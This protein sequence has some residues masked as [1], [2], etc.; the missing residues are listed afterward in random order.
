MV[1]STILGPDGA[2]IVLPDL[3]QPQTAQLTSLQHEWQGHPTRG[4]TPT[5]L[6]GIMDAAEQGDW[7]AQCELYDDMEEKD[8]H[9]AS[10]MGKR[11]RAI[12]LLDWDIVPPPSPYAS[13]KRAAKQVK[14][15]LADIPE[16]EDALFDVTDAIGKGFCCLEIEWH[17]V[18]G[19]WL[20]KTLTH[21]P[22]QWF[23]VQRGYREAIR[24]RHGGGEGE[25]LQPFGWITHTHKAKSGWLA[26]SAL[27]RVLAWPYL[28]KNYSVADLAEFLEIYGIPLRVGK[29]PPGAGEK[30]KLTLLRALA[31]LGHKAA[32]IIPE[33]MLIE[34]QEA[35]KGDP[36]S[37]QLMIDW[38]EKSQSKAILGGTL[39][40]QADGKTSTNALGN[41]HNEVR[42]DLRD[43]DVKQIAA[44]LSR[45]L[46]YAI[47]AL[48]GLAPN[49][50]RRAPRWHYPTEEPEDLATYSSALPPLV[51]MGM[52]IPRKWAQEKLG[53]PEPEADDDDLLIA[54]KPAA[55]APF[56]N[57][58]PAD[59]AAATAHTASATTL[60]V[61]QTS[62]YAPPDLR[63]LD[64]LLDDIEQGNTQQAE[65][66]Q[67][68]QPLLDAA[69]QGEQ[70]LADK[71]GSLFPA[72]DDGALEDALD[73]LLFAAQAWG[74]IN[75]GRR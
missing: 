59:Q 60:P 56:A 21:R 3:A 4:L 72:L 11:R 31:G 15:W 65:A 58:P 28:F 20:P 46:V 30:E 24:L 40:S 9:I 1:T 73:R 45:Q 61:T 33:G 35:T 62:M 47:A 29:Y 36:D 43:A 49:G 2:P 74:A 12:T 53:I 38:C 39:T 19:V 67:L 44:S 54:A 17:R 42:K 69:Q 18:E 55:P 37:Y 32:G 70:A 27:F 52:K 14:E 8:A 7:I 23:V 13:E 25:A 57:P 50:P 16:L 10:E 6:A 5:R 26:R 22:Q 68:L 34:F 64:A 51:G 48:N 66:Q 71:L 75:A 41:V 63:A